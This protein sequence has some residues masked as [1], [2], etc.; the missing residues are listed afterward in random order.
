MRKIKRSKKKAFFGFITGMFEHEN[1]ELIILGVLSLVVSIFGHAIYTNHAQIQAQFDALVNATRDVSY[2]DEFLYIDCT[3]NEMNKVNKDIDM[4]RDKL[5]IFIDQ[6]TSMGTLLSHE[7]YCSVHNFAVWNDQLQTAEAKVCSLQ[8]KPEEDIYNWRDSIIS[9]I[10]KDQIKRQSIISIF[11][12][13][14]TDKRLE[15]RSPTE[16]K[17]TNN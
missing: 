7:A 8:L 12:E 16:C 2:V 6:Y 11:A 10:R 14:F 9:Q 13:Y 15:I 4:L 17:P 3:N 5:K 1:I